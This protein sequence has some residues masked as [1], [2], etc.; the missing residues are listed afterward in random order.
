MIWGSSQCSGQAEELAT[1]GQKDPKKALLEGPDKFTVAR[2]LTGG[3]RYYGNIVYR[4]YKNIGIMF[5][6]ALPTTHKEV[7]SLYM[8]IKYAIMYHS[9]L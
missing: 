1:N 6:D 2:I 8:L 7:Q 5:P 9:S 4:E 3:S